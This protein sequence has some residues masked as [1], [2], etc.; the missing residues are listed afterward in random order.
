MKIQGQTKI[1]GAGLLAALFL[2]CNVFAQ[3]SS[4]PSEM[5]N[6]LAIVLIIVAVALLLAIGLLAYVL[7][8]AAEIY[9]ERFKEMQ[10]KT[11]EAEKSAVLLVGFLCF[12]A[13][14]FAADAPTTTAA[15][16]VSVN[17]YG[18]LSSSSF[19]ML[20]IVI[21]LEIVVLLTMLYYLQQLLAKEKIA[22]T[23]VEEATVE[24][25]P[26][27]KIWWDKLNNFRP[28]QDENDLLLDHDYDGIK[29]LDNRLPTWWVYGLYVTILFSCVYLYRFHIS[30]SAPLSGEE[31]QIAMQ[32]ADEEKETYLKN[33][34]SK[35]DEN[36]VTLMA[37]ASTLGQ[38]KQLYSTVCIACH[39][40]V[41]QG[42]VGPNLTDD[43]WLHKGGIKDIF[44]T[45]KY[46]VAEKGMKSWE[47]DFSPVQM[48]ALAN[49][50]KSLH[51]TKPANPKEPQGD[52]FSEEGSNPS[53]NATNDSTKTTSKEKATA[54][55]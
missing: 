39:G 53:K 14:S 19:Y 54:A 2:Y 30:H 50:V 20:V 44:K 43:Y 25:V 13:W 41:G 32:K 11:Y 7:S 4:A 10:K 8:G 34:A 12:S 6:S 23:I 26:T 21:G 15:S 16:T 35:V 46:G 40:P 47:A 24:S 18:G 51:G 17:N 49:Y 28:A 9:V 42:L 1:K 36:T 52:L 3:G 5:N 31:Y 37:D 45:I 22:S 48:A 38:G 27:W 29:E 33:A 55:Y